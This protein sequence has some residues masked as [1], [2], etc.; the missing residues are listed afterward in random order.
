[1]SASEVVKM[2]HRLARLAEGSWEARF[3]WAMK[4]ARRYAEMAD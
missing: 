1:M 4:V 2:A 3:S